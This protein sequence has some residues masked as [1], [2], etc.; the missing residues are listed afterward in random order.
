MLVRGLGA[1]PGVASGKVRVIGELASADGLFA[2]DH[3]GVGVLSITDVNRALRAFDL[4]SG[5][6]RG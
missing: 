6:R 3:A 2:Q 4:E 5:P 1:A